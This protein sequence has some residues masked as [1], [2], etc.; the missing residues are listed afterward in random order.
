MQIK[1][2]FFVKNRIN[3]IILSDM[4]MWEL[5]HGHINPFGVPANFNLWGERRQWSHLRFSG[6]V[7]FIA[8][9]LTNATHMHRRTRT[10]IRREPALNY[11]NKFREGA[12]RSTT[13]QTPTIPLSFC[14]QRKQRKRNLYRSRIKQINQIKQKNRPI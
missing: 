4:S 14:S 1:T 5:A 13:A 12:C 11:A 7:S 3:S 8:I 2:D 9:H 6:A 10:Y